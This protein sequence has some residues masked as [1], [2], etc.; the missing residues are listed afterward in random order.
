LKKTAIFSLWNFSPSDISQVIGIWDFSI[1]IAF[2]R[3]A[4]FIGR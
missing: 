1:K 2:A 4:D 3:R